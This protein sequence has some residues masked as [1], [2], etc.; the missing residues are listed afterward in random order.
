MTKEK[1]PLRLALSNLVRKLRGRPLNPSPASEKTASEPVKAIVEVPEDVTEAPE[2]VVET[3]EDVARRL[4][5]IIDAAY[6][7][8]LATGVSEEVRDAATKL[9]ALDPGN[10]YPNDTVLAKIAF[11]ANASSVDHAL[12]NYH[13]LL[14]EKSVEFAYVT[15]PH[16]IRDFVRHKTVIDVGCGFGGFG[17]GFQV[18]GAQSY[19]GLDPAMPL[20]SSRA[21]NKRTRE[22]ADMGMKVSEIARISPDIDLI[23]GTA[24]D[25]RTDRTFDLIS[26]HNVTE[27][28]INL[29]TVIEGLKPLCHESTRVIFH[30]HNYYCWNGHH[31][32]PN[33]PHQLDL[34]D[35]E[36]QKIYDWRHI[37]FIPN[38]PED[39]YFKTHL[40]RVRLDEIKRITEANFD[41]LEWTERNSNAETLE[42]L[43]P[44]VLDRVRRTIP[45]LT[46]RDLSVNAVLCVAKPKGGL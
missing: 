44:E 38:I 28:L 43:T 4:I 37:D 17:T 21:K 14:V 39:H 40:N 30:H 46:E 9:A 27:H 29:E 5:A 24:E 16:R 18:A 1:S 10:K 7:E 15:W 31:F 26:L 19:L 36:H 32:R 8:A 3:T 33:Q 11:F 2:E 23:H 6:P 34:T 25:L 35:E 45:D 41:I 42:R 20:D 13:P 12:R 22:W